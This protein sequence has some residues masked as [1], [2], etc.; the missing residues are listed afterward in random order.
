MRISGAR[1][2][3][4]TWH[5]A[6]LQVCPTLFARTGCSVD[7]F[8]TFDLFRTLRRKFARRHTKL[9]LVVA[10][11]FFRIRKTCAVQISLSVCEPGKYRVQFGS[12]RSVSRRACVRP[13]HAVT[14][15]SRIHQG[16]CLKSILVPARILQL[17]HVPFCCRTPQRTV[18]IVVTL[19]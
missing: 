4:T 8:S 1:L 19:R 17:L 18:R 15:I 5:F 6:F 16:T 14:Y 13:T 7:N 3:R 2:D 10:M 9:P 11:K 12:S